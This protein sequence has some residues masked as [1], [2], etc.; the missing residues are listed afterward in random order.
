MDRHV[1]FF[2]APQTRA[3]G[4]LALLE[5][6]QADTRPRSARVECST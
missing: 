4:T 6:L 5:A 2:Y 3:S 1:T